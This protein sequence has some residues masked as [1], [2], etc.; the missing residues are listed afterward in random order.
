[1]KKYQ[2]TPI[3]RLLRGNLFLLINHCFNSP[4]LLFEKFSQTIR[5]K[6]YVI[7]DKLGG[8]KRITNIL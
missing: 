3:T 2:T 4:F 1:M 5:I 8:E 6:D 7:L